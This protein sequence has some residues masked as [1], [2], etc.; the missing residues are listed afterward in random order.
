MDARGSSGVDATLS[1]RAARLDPASSTSPSRPRAGRE[2]PRGRA[3]ATPRRELVRILHDGGEGHSDDRGRRGNQ[4][5]SAR[6]ITLE[7]LGRGAS[8]RARPGTGSGS[9][10][11]SSER[12][13]AGR[14][15]PGRVAR[16]RPRVYH[17]EGDARFRT[18]APEA[19]AERR[20]ASRSRRRS[21][22]SCFSRVRPRTVRDPVLHARFRARLRGRLRLRL[23]RPECGGH[24]R[25]GSSPASD[26]RPAR[27]SARCVG[28]SAR[29]APGRVG[30]APTR[31]RRAA[32]DDVPARPRSRRSRSP[33]PKVRARVIG[34][35]GIGYRRAET[36]DDARP[37]S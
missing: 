31:L 22:T 18:Y 33:T 25:P 20:S 37:T 2:D 4:D 7:M 14:G 36:L 13:R 1:R 26:L 23:R 12:A 34:L 29:A 10:R 5:G 6:K 3:A 17:V 11:S 19:C 35:R 27:R 16:R 8:A 9:G 32:A 28:V 30:P 24:G 21:P 15:R